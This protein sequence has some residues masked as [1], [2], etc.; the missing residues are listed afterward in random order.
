MTFLD[1]PVVS[2]PR[3]DHR[4]LAVEADRVFSGVQQVQQERFISEP[5]GG[6][7]DPV[8]AAQSCQ[9][10]PCRPGAVRNEHV[11]PALPAGPE[12]RVVDPLRDNGDS[13]REHGGSHHTNPG[14]SPISGHDSLRFP[15]Q[16]HA[17]RLLRPNVASSEI[18]FQDRFVGRS[19]FVVAANGCALLNPE[20]FW[21]DC[22][23]L[24]RD[25]CSS[26]GG[27]SRRSVLVL[28]SLRRT[29]W[30]KCAITSLPEITCSAD[31]KL[32][33]RVSLCSGPRSQW[34][35]APGNCPS[36]PHRGKAV[37]DYTPPAA[38]F[39]L[40]LVLAMLDKKNEARAL[41][42]RRLALVEPDERTAALLRQ[43]AEE[44]E[45]GL[46]CTAER[47]RPLPENVR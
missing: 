29:G 41:R 3:S 12:F 2:A 30:C 35:S 22:N 36:R 46:L 37:S 25:G 31:V 10:L 14:E 4:L 32:N 16:N 33:P 45:K 5:A 40:T 28:W 19:R 43:V 1:H 21:R 6:A 26:A 13:G 11:A 18:V 47:A 39:V 8:N 38:L 23:D 9:F 34:S 44:A 42:Y 15:E 24:R 27:A 17:R 20:E 7:P